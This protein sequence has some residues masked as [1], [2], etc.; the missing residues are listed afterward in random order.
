MRACGSPSTNTAIL[1]PSVCTTRER[2][3]SCFMSS[4][5]GC[6][7]FPRA[8]SQSHKVERARNKP[9]RARINS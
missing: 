2:N 9:A 7:N 5:S 1:V 4:T 3:T 8:I 6:T